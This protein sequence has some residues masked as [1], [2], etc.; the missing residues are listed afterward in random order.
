MAQT[1]KFRPRKPDK[2]REARGSLGASSERKDGLCSS[3]KSIVCGIDEAGRGA[4][5]GELVVAGCVFRAGF[6]KE[7]S[8]LNLTDSKKLTEARRERIFDALTPFC[9]YVVVYFRNTIVDEIGLSACLARALNVIKHRFETAKIIY[10]GNCAYGVNGVETMIKADAK[11]PEVSA[12]SIIAKVSRDRQMR[13][14]D[15]L[16]PDFGYAKHKGYGV[17]AHVEALAKYGP[18]DLT[19]RSFHLRSQGSLFD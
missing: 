5:A 14:F 18:N 7:I 19:R 12:A 1:D 15:A 8:N 2:S 16:Y 17:K 3:A 4:L 11:V 6:E 10:D 9:D 13:R